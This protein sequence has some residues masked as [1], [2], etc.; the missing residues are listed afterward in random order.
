MQYMTGFYDRNGKLCSLVNE[1]YR[2][3]IV[4]RSPL[5][6]LEDSIRC[7]GFDLKGALSTAKWI[8]GDI[9]MCPFMVNPI[10]GICVFPTKSSKHEET[11]WFNPCHIVWTDPYYLYTKVK[12]TNGLVITV[13]CRL[14]SF[15]TKKQKAEQLR[16]IT[17]ELATNPHSFMIEPNRDRLRFQPLTDDALK[18]IGVVH[19]YSFVS[20]PDNQRNKISSTMVLSAIE[21]ALLEG[22]LNLGTIH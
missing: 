7:S 21:H 6:I 17:A 5:E 11:I 2:T 14:F 22:D 1:L 9:P 15:N 8:L 3:I 12:L 4:D 13:P 10:Q 20:Y 16:R 19:T 18:N